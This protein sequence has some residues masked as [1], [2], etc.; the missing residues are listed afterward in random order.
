MLGVVVD[1]N[2]LIDEQDRDAIVDPVGAPQPW[3]VQVLVA[4]QQQRTVILGA[5]QDAEQLLVEQG[6]T[7]RSAD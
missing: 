1:G 7:S 3:V 5:D 4:H 6:P 2:C